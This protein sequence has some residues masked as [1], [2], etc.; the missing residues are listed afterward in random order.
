MP[1]RKAETT[2]YPDCVCLYA[3]YMWCV[4]VLP[5]CDVVGGEVSLPRELNV[6][7]CPWQRHGTS[8]VN[9]T[10]I[11]LTP[12]ENNTS[13]RQRWLRDFTE[14]SRADDSC[15]PTLKSLGY[16]SKMPTVLLV[17]AFHPLSELQEHLL[18]L[19]PRDYPL[20]ISCSVQGL[21]LPAILP[22]G[23]LCL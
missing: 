21:R 15:M 16:L 2:N 11:W 1:S 7:F 9:P 5:L 22:R 13:L 19:T 4:C 18:I 17:L 23:L 20:L 8:F 3:L 6:L 10:V 14:P 12:M